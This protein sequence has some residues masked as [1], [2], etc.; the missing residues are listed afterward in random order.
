MTTVTL[1][2]FFFISLRF[3]FNILL[4]RLVLKRVSNSPNVR[5]IHLI[6]HLFRLRFVECEL[7]KVMDDI[8]EMC[9]VRLIFSLLMNKVQKGIEYK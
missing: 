8:N 1:N 6:L 2:E 9:Y 7:T 5:K 3:V 4:P